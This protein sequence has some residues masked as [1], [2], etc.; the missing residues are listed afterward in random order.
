MS[1]LSI[2]VRAKS[3]LWGVV[4]ELALIAEPAPTFSKELTRLLCAL[5]LVSIL[6]A[7][8]GTETRLLPKTRLTS[9]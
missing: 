9:S 8:T 6:S 1:C 7:A 3:T 5:T 4:G 2:V